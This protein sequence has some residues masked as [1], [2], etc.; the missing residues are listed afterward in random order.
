M[1]TEDN[2]L[3]LHEDW[4]NTLSFRPE[5]VY[6]SGSKDFLD[7]LLD[8]IIFEKITVKDLTLD[9]DEGRKIAETL[10]PPVDRSQ[11]VL[12]NGAPVPE[13]D[14]HTQLDSKTGM[15]EDY[16]VLSVEERN[17]G[18]VRPVRRTYT[19]VGKNPNMQGGVLVST[20]KDACGT[21]TSMSQEIAET[22]ARDPK[23]Y[24]GTYC[25]SC[26]KHL[27]LDEFV[28]AG[29]NEKLGS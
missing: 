8:N 4:K 9:S 6:F 24:S 12:V 15:Q 17:K 5:D 27:P 11:R 22:Y 14:S 1:I 16:V 7:F 13:D 2:L 26:K 28:W 19:H 25:Y 10:V 23:F 3:Q 20:P 21:N 29:T 18:F